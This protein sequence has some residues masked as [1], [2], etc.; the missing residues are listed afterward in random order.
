MSSRQEAEREVE[1]KK[2]KTLSQE[3]WK[4]LVREKKTQWTE[5][6]GDDGSTVATANGMLLKDREEHTFRALSS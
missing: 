5:V 2:K 4:L 6:D 3:I 1:E